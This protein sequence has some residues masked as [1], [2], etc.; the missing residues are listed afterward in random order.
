MAVWMVDPEPVYALMVGPHCVQVAE[1]IPP[2]TPANGQLVVARLGD[3]TPDHSCACPYK[4]KQSRMRTN[5]SECLCL[6]S[7]PQSVVGAHCAEFVNDSTCPSRQHP[8]ADSDFPDY[9]D[10]IQ[11][12]DSCKKES[13][14]R[15]QRLKR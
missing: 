10:V 7:F 12:G 5:N 6:I 3:R 2:T 11:G 15:Q 8:K 13:R 1:G 4:G 9:A 14:S